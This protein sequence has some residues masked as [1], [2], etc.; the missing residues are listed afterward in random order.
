MISTEDLL[1]YVDGALDGMIAI[2][3]ELGDERAN[4]RPDVPGTNS[5]YVLLRH[6]LGVMEWWG[7]HVIAGRV[8]V[9]DRDAEFVARGTVA[10]L[11]A[12]ARR[13]R[14]QLAEDLATLDPSAPPRG[15]VDDD[16][17][18]AAPLGRT[19]GGAAVHVFEELAQHHGQME[20]CRDVLVA[21]WARTAPTP[22][23]HREG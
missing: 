15:V 11:V 4:L 12:H 18:A 16:D 14:A 20:G 2:V 8:V 19:Q 17:D 5:P 10:E 3:E 23:T 6:C 22:A 7:G 13:A 9:R 21:P 1:W